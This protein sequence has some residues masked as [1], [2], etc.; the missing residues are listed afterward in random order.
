MIDWYRGNPDDDPYG[1]DGAYHPPAWFQPWT[2]ALVAE[3]P[4]VPDSDGYDV[5][6]YEMRCP[7]NFYRLV[8]LPTKDSMGQER[9]GFAMST[10]SGEAMARLIGQIAK[11]IARGM[12]GPC[13]S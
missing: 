3:L 6:I 8:A 11:A 1:L 12:L 4:K 10:G 9:A 2:W 7:P 13:E 5:Q